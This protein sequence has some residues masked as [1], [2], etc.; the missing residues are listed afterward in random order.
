MHTYIHTQVFFEVSNLM[1]QSMQAQQQG[2]M[3]KGI[4]LLEQC[5]EKGSCAAMVFLGQLYMESCDGQEKS[6][7]WYKK[8]AEQGPAE[9]EKITGKVYSEEMHSAAA[10]RLGQAYLHGQGIKKDLVA[11]EKWLRFSAQGRAPEQKHGCA[12]FL[13]EEKQTQESL[14]DALALLQDAAKLGHGPSMTKLGLHYMDGNRV[15]QD[16]E[17]AERWFREALAAGEH[18]AGILMCVCV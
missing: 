4:R 6:L 2:D 12:M 8:C 16:E 10:A 18:H 7:Y 1:Q 17:L 3:A 15:L 13:Y 14:D 5:A 11:A 9:F